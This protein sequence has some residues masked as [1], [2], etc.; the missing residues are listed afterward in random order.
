VDVFFSRRIQGKEGEYLLE[1]QNAEQ[2]LM[3]LVVDEEN[4]YGYSA[5]NRY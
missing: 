1:K 5:E 2:G 4:V 3:P